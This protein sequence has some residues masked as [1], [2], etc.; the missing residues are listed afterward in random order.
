MNLVTLDQVILASIITFVILAVGYIHK[1]ITEHNA[2]FIDSI[3]RPHRM[4]GK[5]IKLA[6]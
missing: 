2:Y 3:G 6:K 4:N 1:K 5:F